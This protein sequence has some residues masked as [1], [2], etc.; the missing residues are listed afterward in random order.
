MF[1]KIT[2]VAL[3]GAALARRRLQH[4]PRRRKGRELGRELHREHDERQ[5]G[6]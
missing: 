1:Q 6:C 2:T 3:L 4:R 5:P